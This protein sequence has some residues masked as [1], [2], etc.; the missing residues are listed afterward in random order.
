MKDWPEPQS[1]MAAYKDFMDTK[2][3]ETEWVGFID[4][5][6][7]VIP[8]KYDNIYDFLKKFKDKSSVIIYWKYMGSSGLIDRDIN[9]LISETFIVGSKFETMGKFFFNTKFKYEF[10]FKRNGYMHYTWASYKGIKVPPVNLFGHI[11]PRCNYNIVDTDDF[12]IQINHYVIKTYK[13]YIEKKSK[14]GGGVHP[15]THT[16]D[17]FFRH[18]RKCQFPDYSA[19]KYLSELKIAMGNYQK[20]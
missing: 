2:A 18:D 7:Y 20:N 5:D 8:N 14:R 15:N 9:S 16:M 10:D 12:P 17:Y 11:C 4:L 3:N 19:Y 1:Q 13:E 6:E